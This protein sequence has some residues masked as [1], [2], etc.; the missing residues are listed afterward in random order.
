MEGTFYGIVM[1][2][3]KLPV[4]IGVCVHNE[5]HNLPHFLDALIAQTFP[6]A[7]VLSEI[8]V[9]ASGCTDDS[10]P[11][12]KQR[13]RLDSRIKL[14]IERT[15]RGK[16]SGVNKIL[17]QAHGSIIILV[18]ADTLPEEHC[19]SHLLALFRDPKVGMTG[20][21][22]V[23]VDDPDT[24]MGFVTHLQWE[25]HHTLSL[26]HPKMG[27]MVAFRNVWGDAKALIPPDTVHD[28][29]YLEIFF[30]SRGYRVVYVPDAIVYNKGPETIHEFIARRRNI[31]AG[32][33]QLWERYNYRPGTSVTIP[34]AL[35]FIGMMV[36]KYPSYVHWVIAGALLQHLAAT[37][38]SRD[39]ARGVKDP[40]IWDIT[41]SSKKLV[42][43]KRRLVE[44]PLVTPVMEA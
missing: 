26:V 22:P 36:K 18:S 24:F 25:L 11:I 6:K 39:W 10:V 23:P 42:R 29:A 21:H 8:M 31:T 4:S 15:R 9:V 3:P 41:Q 27:E 28:E 38:G 30:R 35:S 33:I 1:D 12:L 37:L 40:H 13:A 17:K 14:V 44:T 2:V 19:I 34:K 16:V 20:A 32:F 7:Y 5:A 43:Q